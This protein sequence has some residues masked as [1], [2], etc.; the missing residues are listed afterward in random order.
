MEVAVSEITITGAQPTLHI[1]ET[2][3]LQAIPMN[4]SGAPLTSREV[5]WST[6]NGSVAR[7]SATGLVTAEAPGEVQIAASHDGITKS[8]RITIYALLTINGAGNG[9]GTVVG[10][11]GSGVSC[12]ITAGGASCQYPWANSDLVPLSAMAAGSHSFGGWGGACSGTSACQV[13]MSADRTVTANFTS[14]FVLSI[15]GSGDGQGVVTGPGG[16][17][18][19]VSNAGTSGTCQA[20][21]AANS[22]VTLVAAVPVGRNLFGGWAGGGC[23]G[24]FS[25]CHV[26]M[27]TDRAVTATFVPGF[28]LTVQGGGSGDGIVIGPDGIGCAISKGTSSGKCRS[29]FAA[30][31]PVWLAAAAS[32]GHTFTGWAGDCGGSSSTC[33]VTVFGDRS[34]RADFRDP[35][36]NLV[37]AIGTA[38]PGDISV[39]SCG[40][41]D[42]PGGNRHDRYSYEL[43]EQ[44]LIRFTLTSAAIP[45]RMVPLVP[46]NRD[47]GLW[48]N[49]SLTNALSIV[50]LARA[51]TY[52]LWAGTAEAT[53]L[54]S[55]TVAS[56]RISPSEVTDCGDVYTTVG[57]TTSFAVSKACTHS[58]NGLSG[59]FYGFRLWVNM[60]QGPLRVRVSSSGFAPLVELR[61]P[62]GQLV[63]SSAGQT[64]S[65]VQVSLTPVSATY[66]T[67]TSR[68]SGQTGPF[69]I[70]I[71]P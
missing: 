27:S 70:T 19:S 29:L 17:N 24:T 28:E 1:G 40:S 12:S 2:M 58:P 64:G 15:Q 46:Q 60:N 31:T 57:V 7:V 10:L 30:N 65:T 20:T 34:V 50:V 5:T 16:I 42:F 9:D 6:S 56:Q 59:T 52:S 36:A 35:C 43:T 33:L 66:I 67:V 22:A 41:S 61:N 45:P 32:T 25:S 49:S 53:R 14:G 21:F 69:T 44:T 54:G 63:G 71:D 37:H 51:G 47:F 38:A 55:Y 3:Q 18:C 11:S 48:Y 26:I 68:I 4:R 8:V 62:Q 39:T 13:A 23:S